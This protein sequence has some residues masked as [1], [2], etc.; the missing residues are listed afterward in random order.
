MEKKKEKK[1]IILD[2]DDGTKIKIW[3]I[4]NVPTEDEEVNKIYKD[5][6]KIYPEMPES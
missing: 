2:L 1:Y 3:D 5:S 6:E 4:E